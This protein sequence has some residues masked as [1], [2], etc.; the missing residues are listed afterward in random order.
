[1]A[2][3]FLHTYVLQFEGHWHMVCM[4]SMVESQHCNAYLALATPKLPQLKAQN[5]T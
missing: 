3:H 4:D 2:K 5:N 1:M